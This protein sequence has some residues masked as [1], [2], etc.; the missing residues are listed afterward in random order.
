[1]CFWL[2]FPIRY[3]NSQTHKEQNFKTLKGV[4]FLKALDI[5][6]LIYNLD[7]DAGT[8]SQDQRVA[9]KELVELEKKSKASEAVLQKARTEMAFHETEMR[10]LYKKL[11]ELEDKKSVRTAKLS[12][13]KNDEEHRSYKRELDNIERDVRDLQKRADDAEERIEQGKKIFK[14]AEHELVSALKASEGEQEKARSARDSSAGRLQE[15]AKVRES[16]LDQLDERVAQHYLRVAKI[17]HNA[18]GPISRV[19]QSV[20]GNCRM[21]LSPLILN[22]LAL[23]KSVEFCPYCSHILLP[24]A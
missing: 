17:T 1:M 9:L 6:E 2:F 15:I 21:D 14:Q 11:D 7:R 20:C 22:H 16:Y 3:A 23:G 10:R 4:I 13:A 8:V 24:S 12:L 5:I 19:V 18:D